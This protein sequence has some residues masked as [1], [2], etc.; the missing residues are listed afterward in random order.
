MTAI[1]NPPSV[2]RAFTL[3]ELLVVIAIIAILIGLLLPAVQKVRAAA[4]RMQCA[5]N[6][7]QLALAAHNFHDANNAFPHQY[8]QVANTSASWVVA[9]APYYEQGAFYQQYLT[10][11]NRYQ[12]GRAALVAQSFKVLVCPADLIPT[13]AQY[14][15]SRNYPHSGTWANWWKQSPDGQWYGITS[16]GGNVGTKG[17]YQGAAARVW[18]GVIVPSAVP[19]VRITDVTDGASNTLLFGETDHTDPLW[20]SFVSDCKVKSPTWAGN[21]PL[22]YLGTWPFGDLGMVAARTPLNLR[23]PPSIKTNP[24]TC[25]SPAW[26]SGYYDKADNIGSGHPG[27][28]NVALTDGSV[29]FL[30][31]ALSLITL[32]ALAS[33]SGGEV[34]AESY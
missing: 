32:Q 12:G 18:D 5:N 7:K 13:S 24:P 33:R 20:D 23:L 11:P 28:A 15:I 21:G 8:G 16:Y 4:A 29:R 6:L 30:R 9:L 17:Y 27:G 22:S 26:L 10:S 19:A 3:I 31:D 2:R 25:S 1:F 14:E 34:I